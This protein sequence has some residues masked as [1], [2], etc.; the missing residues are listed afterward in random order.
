MSRVSVA[1]P[2]ELLH[3]DVSDRA[4]RL[5]PVLV[6]MCG[7][8]AATR[9]TRPQLATLLRCSPRSVDAAIAD[10]VVAGWLRITWR[11]AGG[12]NEYEPLRRLDLPVVTR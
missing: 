11:G 8:S 12:A 7:R 9:A 4:L 3:A 6:Q 5:W 1:V 2:V 10:L